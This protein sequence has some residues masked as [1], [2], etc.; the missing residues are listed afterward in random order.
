MPA[1]STCTPTARAH[2]RGRRSRGRQH[3]VC[4]GS[5]R[6]GVPEERDDLVLDGGEVDVQLRQAE[7]NVAPMLHAP[8]PTRP[9]PTCYQTASTRAH[10]CTPAHLELQLLLV[11]RLLLVGLLLGAFGAL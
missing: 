8:A 3:A 4:D 6:R 5:V 1:G 9:H 2:T 7:G 11:F 10:R